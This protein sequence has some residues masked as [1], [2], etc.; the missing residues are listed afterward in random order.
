M[1]NSTFDTQF[2]ETIGGLRTALLA[3]Y[4]AV[5][6][7][8][9]Q[10]Q[11]VSRR[12]KVNKTLTWKTAKAIREEDAFNAASMLPGTSGLEIL[13][14]SLAARGGAPPTVVE[15][16][17][18][19]KEAFNRMVKTHTDDRA[20]L[21]LVLDAMGSGEKPLLPSRIMAFRGSSGIWGLQCQTQVA[22]RFM[23]PS[24]TRDGFLDLARIAGWTGVRRLRRI[25][26]WPL[27]QIALNNDDGSP[28]TRPTQP[29]PLT[30]S[31]EPDRWAL[32]EFRESSRESVRVHETARGVT[33]ELQDGEVG[34]LGESDYFFGFRFPEAVPRFASEQNAFGEF[35]PSI[36]IPAKM[37]MLDL[38]IHAD[39]AE[40]LQS[41]VAAYGNLRGGDP[42]PI[43]ALRIP[44]SETLLRMGTNPR[45]A[46]PL[47]DRYPE[48]VDLVMR[49][50]GWSLKDFNL[51]RLRYEYPPMHA[52]MSIRYPLPVA[53]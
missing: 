36:S 23:A 8:P 7:D 44:M 3:L 10:P 1:S 33:F 38:F 52:T 21:E 4:R 15:N 48:L 20:N 16:A 45:V 43:A 11:E 30:D 19:A 24:A 28:M 53:P 47:V 25:D 14:D 22:A 37:L 29:I 9:E 42:E 40:A 51:L 18:Q 26:G 2:R 12:F 17:R 5:E 41:T 32:S 31:D 39:L 46:T 27:L 34:R 6:A 35:R 13:I 49:R 50:C